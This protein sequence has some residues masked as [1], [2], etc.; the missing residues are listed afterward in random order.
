VHSGG[1]VG[2]YKGLAWYRKH[3]KL[4]ADLSGRKVFLEFEGMRQAGDIF[5]NG[6]QIGLYENG[7]TAYGMDISGAVQFGDQENVRPLRSTTARRT[8]NATRAPRLNGTPTISIP[9]SKES[10]GTSGYA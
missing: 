4:P 2:T 8:L 6:K 5:L 1:D 10:T 3:F 9:I 7:I